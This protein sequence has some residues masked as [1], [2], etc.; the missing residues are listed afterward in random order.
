MTESE[1]TKTLEEKVT[2]AKEKLA[3][4]LN[5][6][7]AGKANPTLLDRVYVDYYETPT[8]LKSLANTAAI[9]PVTLSVSPFDPTNL[10]A[11]EK[12]I[13]D[14][15]LGVTTVNDGKV[16]RITIP[17]PTEERRK[18]L[19][20]EVK[21]FLEEARISLRGARHKANE[22]FERLEKD[23]EFTEDDVKSSKKGVQK[24]IDAAEGDIEEATKKKEAELLEI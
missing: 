24:L 8:P 19:A 12:G 17:K 13:V 14:A 1:I 16:V 15:D 23:G 4:E 21:K 11:I 5:T 7:R 2:R 9:D 6:I 20:K 22:G 18:E 10:K 3:S